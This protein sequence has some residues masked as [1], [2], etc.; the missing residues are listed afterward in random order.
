MH[1]SGWSLRQLPTPDLHVSTS[2]PNS[3]PPS[4]PKHAQWLQ[5]MP[6]SP[7]FSQASAFASQKPQPLPPQRPS[8]CRRTL[9]PITA[10][11]HSRHCTAGTRLGL[12]QPRPVHE[13]GRTCS[14][15]C[16]AGQALR[17][18]VFVG[19]EGTR[20]V[21][22][23]RQAPPVR[24]AHHHEGACASRVGTLLAQWPWVL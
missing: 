9:Q 2:T 24:R 1:N 5:S 16:S 13:L 8:S 18:H 6:L 14:L 15:G 23:V 22:Y 11:P 4:L 20:L 19:T 7:C 12:R 10:A 17:R 21:T 3:L